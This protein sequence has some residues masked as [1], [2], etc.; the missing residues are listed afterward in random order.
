MSEFR[1]ATTSRRLTEI[2]SISGAFIEFEPVEAEE[3]NY[4]GQY[5]WNNDI[6]AVDIQLVSG[7]VLRKRVSCCFC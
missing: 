1:P 6:T 5:L 4:S 3:K 7:E 2:V